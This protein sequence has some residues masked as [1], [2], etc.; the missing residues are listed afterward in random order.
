MKRP[1]QLCDERTC[2]LR[3]KYTINIQSNDGETMFGGLHALM[4]QAD[5]NAHL[6]H[7]DDYWCAIVPTDDLALVENLSERLAVVGPKYHHWVRMLV[8]DEEHNC[9][10]FERTYSSDGEMHENIPA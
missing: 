1:H 6:H 3:G 2:A 4:E 8:W 7:S 10:A 5:F 9:I